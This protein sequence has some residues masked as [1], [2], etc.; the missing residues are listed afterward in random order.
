MHS[1]SILLFVIS[2]TMDSFIVGL[3]YG[4]K[5]IRIN[6]INNFVVGI[7]SGLGTLISM[8]AGKFVL[9]YISIKLANIIGGIILLSF[10][11][12]FILLSFKKKDDLYDKVLR[13]PE[14]ADKNNS[15]NIEIKESIFLGIAL[16]IN[17]LGLGIGA[18]ITGLNPYITSFISVIFSMIFIK[19]GCSLG[20]SV[21]SKILSKYGEIISGIIIIALAIY[22]LFI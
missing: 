3:T 21:F 12:Y 18:S 1:I 19:L 6:F 8:L 22:E 14:I 4:I 10:G 17:N 20:N 7:I 2:S 13:N 11:I 16:S 5:K 9:N 15:K